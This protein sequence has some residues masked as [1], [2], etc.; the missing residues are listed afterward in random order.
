[1]Y[2]V[3]VLGVV[4]FGVV[5]VV[6]FGDGGGGSSCSVSCEIGLGVVFY[7]FCGGNGIYNI[8][9]WGNGIGGMLSIYCS[10]LIVVVEE[11]VLVV[12]VIIFNFG[13]G[14]EVESVVN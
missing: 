10:L 12:V 5:F 9:G 2:V 13:S 3:L 7:V 14:R 4:L 1:M 8:L 6:E 11:C